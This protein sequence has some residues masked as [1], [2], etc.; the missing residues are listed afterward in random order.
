MAVVS[1]PVMRIGEVAAVGF[2]LAAQVAEGEH[3]HSTALE[4]CLSELSLR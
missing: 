3:S 1:S 4:W 2:D